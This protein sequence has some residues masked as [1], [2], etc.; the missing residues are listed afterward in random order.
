MATIK[1]YLK[2]NDREPTDDFYQNF[3][4]LN[5]KLTDYSVF[6][7]S[8]FLSEYISDYIGYDTITFISSVINIL[9]LTFEFKKFKFNTDRIDYKNY[10]LNEFIYLYIMYLILCINQG[11]IS[12]IPL[13]IIKE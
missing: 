7:I 3:N 9:V 4:N 8:S 13:T 2:Q 11:I 10:S 12:L 1:S 5:N 6:F